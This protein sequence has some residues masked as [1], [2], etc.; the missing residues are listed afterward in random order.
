MIMAEDRQHG[1]NVL[2]ERTSRLTYISFLE[3]KTAAATKQVM[4]RKLD[5]YPASLTQSITYDNGRETT[6][7][8]ELN[9]ALG[10]TSFFCV[11]YHC[12]EEGR[13]E[14]ING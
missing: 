3:N 14:H 6:C 9:E 13:V 10:T 4:R 11:P 2:V 7:H 12:W 8:E 5:A 1:L